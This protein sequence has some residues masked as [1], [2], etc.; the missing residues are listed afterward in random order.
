M[1]SQNQKAYIEELIT[2]F[3]L[4]GDGDCHTRVALFWNGNPD[5]KQDYLA[6][7]GEL[8]A[9]ARVRCE[10]GVHWSAGGAGCRSVKVLVV[11]AIPLKWLMVADYLDAVEH[12][13]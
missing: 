11:V 3:C 12:R 4:E 7:C 8:A 2:D 6:A 10:L 1:S 13:R 9:R 5:L